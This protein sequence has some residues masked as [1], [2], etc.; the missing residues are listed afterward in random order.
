MFGGTLP[1][2]PCNVRFKLSIWVKDGRY[3]YEFTD[4][5]DECL[6]EGSYSTLGVLTNR[7]VYKEK[8]YGKIL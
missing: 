2:Y 7:E 5:I 3:K 6:F 8:G 1:N 4:F